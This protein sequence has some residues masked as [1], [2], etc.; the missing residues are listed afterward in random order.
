MVEVKDSNHHSNHLTTRTRRSR[1]SANSAS[2]LT[3]CGWHGYDKCGG[4]SL[5][6]VFVGLV[7]LYSLLW[8]VL[9]ISH[10]DHIVR[11]D[12]GSGSNMAI[13]LGPDSLTVDRTLIG[14]HEDINNSTSFTLN[15]N[16]KDKLR[17]R[18]VADVLHASGGT[19]GTAADAV[20]SNVGAADTRDSIPT[21]RISNNINGG[22]VHAPAP[23]MTRTTV[24]TTADTTTTTASRIGDIS[25][26]ESLPKSAAVGSGV[27]KPDDIHSIVHIPTFPSP[28]T[29]QHHQTTAAA[30]TSSAASDGGGNVAN[31]S[32]NSTT[33]ISVSVAAS[34]ECKKKAW[35]PQYYNDSPSES[36]GGK[37]GDGS[38]T[39]IR[40]HW[41]DQLY[42]DLKGHQLLTENI[43]SKD[44]LW[45]N[46]SSTVVSAPVSVNSPSESE[47][48]ASVPGQLMMRRRRAL[49][50]CGWVAF[51]N[52]EAA[53]KKGGPSGEFVIWG[54]LLAGMAALGYRLTV[55]N[56]IVD[57]WIY[58]KAD[59][60]Y[61]DVIITDYD[62]LGT[63]ENIGHFP[64][65]HCR[66]FVVDGFGTQAAFNTKRHLDL[67]RILVPYEFDGS[68][69]VIHMVTAQLPREQW[70]D[71][72]QSDKNENKMDNSKSD[73]SR[74]SDGNSNSAIRPKAGLIWAKDA[75]YFR[76]PLVATLASLPREVTLRTT[77]RTDQQRGSGLGP[78][79]GLPNV[80]NLGFHKKSEYLQ[81]LTEHRF[82]IGVGKPLDGPTPLEAIA[83]GCAYIN[84]RFTPPL[85]ITGKPTR[86]PYTSQHPFIE[87]HIGPPHAY[88]VDILNETA[89]TA[90]VKEIMS[91]PEPLEP[92][93]H[94]YHR[95]EG[96]V[97]NLR[98]ILTSL[99]AKCSSDKSVP[100]KHP[101]NKVFPTYGAF[102]RANCG[103]QC[104]RPD[105]TQP[106]PQS[107]QLASRLLQ[108]PDITMDYPKYWPPQTPLPKGKIKQKQQHPTVECDK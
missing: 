79:S 56:K 70:R 68:N 10:H 96:Y 58:L 13:V 91:R 45:R 86:F 19:V 15:D 28:L 11:S 26:P 65:Y 41:L 9:H 59:P 35:A 31:N 36:E 107:V 99:E 47:S 60:D 94:P 103:G 77:L 72:Y 108:H 8:L 37:G 12:S 33:P 83:H 87:S 4:G 21:A 18:D 89:L 7:I 42:R 76:P 53:A 49:I 98:A 50:F 46:L 51:W 48:T 71:H 24:T 69:S 93:V 62:G 84:P 102:V 20:G 92:F 61:F 44:A 16:R 1:R 22:T 23:V 17:S 78:L 67:K 30:T 29:S 90:I 82:L 3:C 97:A 64:A 14:F 55:I 32:N 73:S 81:L 43:Q 39:D 2:V 38:F 54:D 57:M 6:F 25:H 105:W 40:I 106:T 75:T 85:V 66:Y 80:V 104:H 63:A 88:T 74:Y 95:P 27:V 34:V 5:R 52:M 101:G 100:T